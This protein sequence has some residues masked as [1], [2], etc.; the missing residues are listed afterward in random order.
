MEQEFRIMASWGPIFNLSTGQIVVDDQHF[1]L[2]PNKAL[3][4]MALSVGKGVYAN[5]PYDIE[6]I[7][8]YENNFMAW[9]TILLRDGSKVKVSIGSKSKKH[10]LIAALEKRRAA[11]FASRGHQLPLLTSII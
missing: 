11:L 2:V 6:N 9:M 5:H 7:A 1:T 8:G 4:A 10:E 3:T